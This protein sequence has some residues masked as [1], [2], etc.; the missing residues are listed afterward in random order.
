MVGMKVSSGFVLGNQRSHL[1]SS[2]KRRLFIPSD[3]AYGE[4]GVGDLIPPYSDLIFDI[5]V[6]GIKERKIESRGMIKE[7]LE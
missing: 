6:V 3:M 5:E 7:Q 4:K 2:E 1:I